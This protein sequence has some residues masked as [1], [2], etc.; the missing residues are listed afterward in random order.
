[1]RV[2]VRC[3]TPLMLI[4][5]VLLALC[6]SGMSIS[7]LKVFRLMSLAQLLRCVGPLMRLSVVVAHMQ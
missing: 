4:W 7:L 6:L 5:H 1:M 3:H 2:L